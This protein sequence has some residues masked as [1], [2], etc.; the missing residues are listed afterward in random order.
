MSDGTIVGWHTPSNRPVTARLEETT[1]FLR[2]SFGQ[3]A[4]IGEDGITFSLPADQLVRY[5]RTEGLLEGA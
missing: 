1:I 5:M 4:G 2:V 3:I